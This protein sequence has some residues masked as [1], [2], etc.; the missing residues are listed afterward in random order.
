MVNLFKNNIKNILIAF[1]LPL[2]YNVRINSFSTFL[3]RTYANTCCWSKNNVPFTEGQFKKFPVPVQ[4]IYLKHPLIIDGST[5]LLQVGVGAAIA[6]LFTS[7][8]PLGGAIFVVSGVVTS[9]AVKW[10]YSKVN[11]CPESPMA[12]AVKDAIP[13]VAGQYAGRAVLSLAGFH[14]T[15]ISSIILSMASSLLAP[16]AVLAGVN[17]VAHFGPQNNISGSPT[18]WGRA[19]FTSDPF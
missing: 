6:R 14:V 13:Q 4:N 8:S 5:T 9:R 18:E 11:Y 15:F 17:M 12:K 2:I 10:V 16:I 7:I 1:S 19:S 3:R